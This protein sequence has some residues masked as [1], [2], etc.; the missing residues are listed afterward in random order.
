VYVTVVLPLVYLFIKRKEYDM[1][2]QL[3]SETKDIPDQDH[4]FSGA[5]SVLDRDLIVQGTN[6]RDFE[7]GV[8]FA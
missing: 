3:V 2:A 8:R 7:F 5:R 1:W 6:D 4:H